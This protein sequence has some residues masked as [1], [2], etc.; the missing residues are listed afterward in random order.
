MK[1]PLLGKIYIMNALSVNKLVKTYASG[2]KALK[3]V[4][5]NI[6][7]GSFYALLGE[8]GAGKTTLIS[9]A[10]SLQTKTS[11]EVSIFGTN[12]SQDPSKAKQYVGLVPQ[13]FNFSI[14]EKVIDIVV[15][16]AG[17]FGI[18]R[19]EALKRA[20]DVLTHLGL[21]DKKDDYSRNLSGGMKRRLLIARA[22][23]HKPRLLFLDEPTAGVDVGL[24][25]DMW[26]YL[27]KLNK[28]EGVTVLLTTHYLEEVEQ[29]CESAAIIKHGEIVVD[30]T[31]TNLLKTLGS[32]VYTVELEDV[33]QKV[34][35]KDFQAE[36]NK[37]N[38]EVV[39]D[40]NHDLSHLIHL[41]D[42]QKIK[43]AGIRPKGN[44]LEEL[45]LSV[46]K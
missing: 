15:W 39:I 44:R 30:D 41:F 45:F 16:Q 14:F 33:S 2:T 38:I 46:N 13:E 34:D 6:P 23:M 3:S 10:S 27:K 35:L 24:R 1:T 37:G 28:E 36:M 4:D 25:I 7:E 8:N 22:L 43:I 18:P 29:N 26:K 40:K 20:E 32:E 19:K 31:V 42:E 11:G 21:W 17:Y 5:L 9:I 12:I